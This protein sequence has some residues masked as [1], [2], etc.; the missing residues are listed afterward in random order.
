MTQKMQGRR[1]CSY[2]PIEAIRQGDENVVELCRVLHC[3][4]RLRLVCRHTSLARW[5]VSLQEFELVK[6]AG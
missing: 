1:G 3:W 2:Q 5:C 4:H 6:R